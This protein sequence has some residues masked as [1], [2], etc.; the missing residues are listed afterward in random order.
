MEIT[1]VSNISYQPPGSAESLNKIKQSFDKLGS[2]LESGDLSA[3]QNAM[4][5]LQ[6]NAPPQRSDDN[7]PIKT[8][9]EK[10][11]QALQSGDLTAAKEAYADVQ[12]TMAQR[13]SAGGHP[14]GP[15]GAT[16]KGA[17]QSS[18]ATSSS[19]ETYDKMDLNKDG[20]VTAMEE[21]LY[22]IEHPDVTTTS[23]S[24]DGNSDSQGSLDVTA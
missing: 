2:A 6:K 7:N 5:E 15:G 18:G 19:N 10:L 17:S 4:A 8:K 24:T 20:T 11:S 14:G 9:M 13:P 23:S 3:A 21:I 12:K 22:G 1:S 16:P